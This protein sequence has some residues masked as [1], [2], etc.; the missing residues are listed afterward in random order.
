LSVVEQQNSIQHNHFFNSFVKDL[1]ISNS[2]VL[3]ND[4]Y[5]FLFVEI[6]IIQ[7]YLIKLKSYHN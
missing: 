6:K 3:L 5:I 1:K 2:L 4:I 7:L